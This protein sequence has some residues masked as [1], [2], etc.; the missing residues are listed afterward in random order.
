MVV[1]NTCLKQ[2][3]G[4]RILWSPFASNCV[5]STLRR[6]QLA[7]FWFA[8]VFERFCLIGNRGGRPHCTQP[9]P[10]PTHSV[11]PA[12]PIEGSHG[13]DRSHR[14]LYKRATP[15]HPPETPA[16]SFS[17]HTWQV[18]KT[19]FSRQGIHQQ[20]AHQ[21]NPRVSEPRKQ[22]TRHPSPTRHAQTQ[23]PSHSTGRSL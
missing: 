20:A 13:S 12:V 23:N 11:S 3:Y 14:Q 5:I 17:P 8:N 6:S 21:P 10:L 4:M 1:Y 9:H 15:H 19:V 2:K 18:V 7:P 22:D 16:P